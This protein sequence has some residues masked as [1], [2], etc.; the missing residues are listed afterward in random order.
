MS[1]MSFDPVLNV[2][3]NFSLCGHQHSYAPAFVWKARILVCGGIGKYSKLDDG[4]THTSMVEEFDPETNTWAVS[5]LELPEKLSSHFI[6][7]IWKGLSQLHWITKSNTCVYIQSLEFLLCEIVVFVTTI[8]NLEVISIVW[9][10]VCTELHAF[11]PV[12]CKIWSCIRLD[13][14]NQFFSVEGRFP[15]VMSIVVCA[16]GGRVVP[17]GNLERLLLLYELES[18]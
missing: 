13:I 9:M 3:T 16:S 8:V 15:S 17:S 11:R 7:G 4:T 10:F 5:Q 6:F 1:C 14:V 2:W 12:N 18:F